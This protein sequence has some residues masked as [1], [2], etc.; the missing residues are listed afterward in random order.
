MM[1]LLFEI[2]KGYVER[3]SSTLEGPLELEHV[4]NLDEMTS[5]RR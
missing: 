5:L 1:S 3:I 4:W 2:L